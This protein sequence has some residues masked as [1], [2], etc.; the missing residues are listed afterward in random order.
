MFSKIEQ[1]FDNLFMSVRPVPAGI[2]QYQSPE[3]A[4][5]PYKWHLRIEG[6]GSGMLVINASTVLHLNQTAAEYAYYLAEGKKKT[7]II[8]LISGRYDVEVDQA[9]KDLDDFINKVTLLINSED[10]DPVTYMDM[11]RVA[12]HSKKLSAPLRIDC[13]LTYNV[14]P[15]VAS[16]VAPN[17]RVTR[18]LTTKEWKEALEIIWK[19]GVPHVVFTGGEP[20]MR[21]DLPDLIRE[22]EKIGLVSGLLTDGVKLGEKKYLMTI[23]ESGLDHIMLLADET[24]EAFWKA[25]KLLMPADIAVTVHATLTKNNQAGFSEFITKLSK[26]AVT[27]I[28]LSA[29]DEILSQ[30]LEDASQE[31]A[32]LG[33]RLVWD[34]PVPYSASH[35][36]AFEQKKAGKKVLQG[37]GKVWLYIEPDG[38]VLP[39]QGI[40]KVKGNI[41]QDPWQKIWSRR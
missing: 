5:L 39:A 1:V 3:D 37:A 40:N 41:L 22:T 11:D 29:E 34:L 7:E 16:A 20:T 26:E 35:P 32:A 15:G 30:Q 12:P 2:Y 27:S 18:E 33:M 23:L 24:S 4:P 31:T 8:Q 25:L 21:P 38:D 19:A 17:E 36:V 28:S 6:D 10:L 14:S 13:A 9:E